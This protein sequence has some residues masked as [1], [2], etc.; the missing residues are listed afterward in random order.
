M[1]MK[2]LSA[3]SISVVVLLA[4]PW[5]TAQVPD[6]SHMYARPP[7]RLSDVPQNPSAP[8]GILP[9]QFKA[10]YGFNRIPN[11]GQGQT[12]AL[13]DAYADPNIESDV[14][15]YVNYFH[16]PPCN[17][18]VVKVGD[19]L[20]N[21]FWAEE[22]SLDV[23]QACALVPQADIILVEANSQS[24]TDLLAAVQVAYSAPYN[25]T[26]ISMSWGYPEFNGEN[27][28]DSYFCNIVNG[29]G[30]PVT[31]VA[32]SGDD[33]H[34]T[35]LYPGA[36]NCVIAA[37]GTNLVLSTPRPLPNPTQLDYGVETA[38]FYGSGGVSPYEAQLAFQNPACA[39]WST[40]NRC[41]PDIASVSNNIPLYD[42]YLN[43]GWVN[44]AGTSISSPDWASFFTL[45]NSMR[46]SQGKGTLSQ[47]AQDL[48]TIYYSAN[49]LTDFHDITTGNNG[50]CG[51][52]C[53][54]GPGYD[55][56]TGIGTYQA[57]V[58][59]PALVADPD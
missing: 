58:L 41:I 54:A 40:I 1:T 17:F 29:N 47:A 52:E 6:G 59:A 46:A 5:L 23:E 22:E 21:L 14:A 48:Y 27:A 39:T 37:G 38:W 2:R 25:A 24:L 44:V 15:Y 49:Y 43:F 53:N 10:A 30:Q 11:Q 51:S 34:Q 12:M 57:N 3:S 13:V 8:T 36:S 50:N 45:V 33:T 31:F 32:A 18:R 42:T 16:L 19:P 26:V 7:I 55:L 28:Y 4:V 56:V 35:T 9:A 20:N